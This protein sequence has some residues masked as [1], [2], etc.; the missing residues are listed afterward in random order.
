MS[1][2]ATPH[3]V[4]IGAGP[5]GLASAMILAHRGFQVTVVEKEDVVGGRSRELKLGEYSFDTGPTFLHQKF[6]LDEVFQEAGRD[7]ED[8]LDF[9]QLDPMTRLTWNDRSLQTYSDQEKME[10]ELEDVFPG[11]VEGFRRFMKDQSE[12]FRVVYPVLQRPFQTIGSY[13]SSELLR[14]LKHI[15]TGKSVIN[16]LEKYFDDEKLRLAFT[17]QAKY[18]GMS[19]WKCPAL[20]TILAYTEYK[21][22]VFHTRG[23]LN[24]IPEAMAKVVIEEG[25]KIRTDSEVSEILVEGKNM[26]GVRLKSGETIKADDV[27]VNADFGQAMTSLLNG[28]GTPLPKMRK[29]EFS[30]STFMLYLGI[31]TIYREEPHHHVIFADDYR[32]N[33]E[34]IQSEERI[35]D[36][37]SIYVRNSSLLDP[38]TAPEGHSALYVLV[39]MIN[40]R[41]D[42]DWDSL[43]QDYRDKVI[44]RIE[45][46]TSMK[47]LSDR[48]VEEKI[49]TP[50]DWEKRGVFMGATFNLSHN[51]GQMLYMRPHNQYQG[52]ENCFL[53]GGG[54]H[55]GSGLPTIYESARISSNLI[56]DRHDIEYGRI[57]LA[58]AYIES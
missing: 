45:E 1:Q 11:S 6:V 58:T 57:D 34:D 31:D 51:L 49:L 32:Q 17:F 41:H 23:G 25:G 53:V 35:S 2:S 19:P 13:L 47:D 4:V 26:T 3:I 15:L 46:K 54:T 28:R 36:D 30:C 9:V 29:K 52:F 10:A 12:K 5:G 14:T 40:N 48:I 55:P 18:L 21:F 44:A 39:P 33:V 38:E 50:S 37:M 56:C 43:K 22:G 27:I 16:A 24:K 20:F 8:Y 7:S 42:Q